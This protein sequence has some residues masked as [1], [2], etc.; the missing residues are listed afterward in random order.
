ME[1]GIYH[2]I[3]SKDY[4][5]MT[6]IVSNSYLGRLAKVPAA[7]KIPQDETEAMK[8]GR[9][10]HCFVLEGEEAFNKYFTVIDI[11]PT[12]PNKRSTQ[13]TIDTY[14]QWLQ[15]L[16]GQQP[17]S[18]DDMQTIHKM[19]E[20]VM[21]HPFAS[22]LLKEGISET[23][24]IWQ[25]EETGLQCKVR[26]DRIP[27]G[28]KGVVLD[29]KSTTN[30]A[31]NAFQSDCVKFGYAREGAMYLEGFGR[32][33]GALYQDLIFSL[34][35]VE[36]EEPYR[37]EVYT[38]ESDFLEYGYGEFHRLLQ[39]EKICRDNNYWPHYQNAG[40]ESLFKPAYVKTWEWESFD[41][42]QR[43]YKRGDK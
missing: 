39:L 15:G 13:K 18:L 20:A 32:L 19:H 14:N 38:L 10:F 11:F 37:C 8:F 31:R 42:V 27:D 30:A 6:D 16:C 26:P 33:T 9:A 40:A 21:N 12:K 1:T 17:V 43:D 41:E 29:L 34:I 4:H 24:I 36:K 3:S 7:A 35:A 23:T 5:A 28:N 2:N 22:K 25:D